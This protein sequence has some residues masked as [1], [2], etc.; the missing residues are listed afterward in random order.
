[1]ATSPTPYGRTRTRDALQSV[2]ESELLDHLTDDRCRAI[3]DAVDDD[4]H[5]A[6]ELIDELDIP[7]ST[8]YR[9]VDSLVD[10]GL[11]AERTRIGG[12]GNHKSEYVRRLDDLSLTVDFSS[13]IE[14][15]LADGTPVDGATG[16]MIE[17]GA[18]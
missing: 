9:K 18:D 3:L 8:L 13:G 17:A 7:R 1:M 4:A 2:D 14:I 11:L 16:T 5:T 10:A 12:D 15:Q 6:G